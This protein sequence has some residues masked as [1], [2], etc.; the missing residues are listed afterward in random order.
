[1]TV[2]NH[3]IKA[4]RIFRSFVRAWK[5]VEAIQSSWDHEGMIVQGDEGFE[6]ILEHFTLYPCNFA[7]SPHLSDMISRFH[8]HFSSG[9]EI[10]FQNLDSVQKS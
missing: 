8:T 1:M 7:L 6:P 4:M 3:E 9:C 10:S 2:W 5:L